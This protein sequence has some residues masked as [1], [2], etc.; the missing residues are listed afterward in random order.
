MKILTVA[1]LAFFVVVLAIGIFLIYVLRM[2]RKRKKQRAKELES[3]S[4]EYLESRVYNYV[5]EYF[6][7]IGEESEAV[8]EF[9]KLIEEKNISELNEKCDKLMA[10]FVKLERKTGYN[11]RPLL[12]DFY[13]D[14]E[15]YVQ[16][17]YKR[18]QIDV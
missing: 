6:D 5:F 7:D 8:R 16:E 10:E 18:K 3:S 14:Y 12:L 9:Y 1:I 4:I 11:G 15:L 13:F 2:D 17:L